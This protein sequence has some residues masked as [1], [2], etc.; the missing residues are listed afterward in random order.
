MAQIRLIAFDL[1]GTLLRDDKTVSQRT[2]EAL[3]KAAD[4]GVLLVPASGRSVK[5]MPKQ[6]VALASG[7]FLIAINGAAVYNMENEELLYRAD[8]SRQETERMLAYFETVPALVTCYW[9][10]Q[11]VVDEQDYPNLESYCLNPYTFRTMSGSYRPVADM[12]RKVLSG[13]GGVQKLQLSFADLQKRRQVLRDMLERFPEYAITSSLE[14][15]IEINTK[16]ANKGQ[17]LAVLC[18]YLGLG[19]ENCMAF[20]DGTNDLEMLTFAGMGVAMGNGVP[21]VRQRCRYATCT[22]NEDGVAVFLERYFSEL[23]K[24]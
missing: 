6:A 17:A 15:N 24:A 20:G 23:D 1:D 13:E 16:V 2:L 3:Q 19:P 10:G 22:N 18:N 12:R 8:L 14:N 11:G 7:S 21:E 9:N 4:R 5:N